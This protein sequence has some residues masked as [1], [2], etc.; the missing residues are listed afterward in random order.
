MSETQE[1]FIKRTVHVCP[2][3]GI[4]CDRKSKL[5]K[6]IAKKH[7]KRTHK[8]PHGDKTFAHKHDTSRHIEED[9][10]KIKPH[11]CQLCDENFWLKESLQ[12]RMQC[13]H[14]VAPSV[15]PS[16]SLSE[17][18]VVEVT[19]DENGENG[20]NDENGKHGDECGTVSPVAVSEAASAT[21]SPSGITLREVAVSGVFE[22]DKI[23]L[24]VILPD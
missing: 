12:K 8:C 10:M 9:H 15:A 19:N 20:Q 16:G 1:V 4:E 23:V 18:A 7:P 5:E 2:E 17:P 6:H 3:C 24:T 21:S 14:S 11:A 22:G 13:Q